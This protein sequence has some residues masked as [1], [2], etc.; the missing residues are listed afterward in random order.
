MKTQTKVIVNNCTYST[1]SDH[2]ILYVDWEAENTGKEAAEFGWQNKCIQDDEG[3][4]FSPEKGAD[5]RLIQPLD[6]TGE[7]TITYILPSK[8]NINNLY[9]GLYHGDAELGLKYK[10]KLTPVNQK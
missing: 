8:V 10:I 2:I 4:V 1:V 6:K 9:W 5:S 7:L 3:R